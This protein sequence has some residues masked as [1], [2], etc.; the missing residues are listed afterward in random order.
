MTVPY[1]CK[2]CGRR[3]AYELLP[4]GG[5]SLGLPTYWCERCWGRLCGQPLAAWELAREARVLRRMNEG[6]EEHHPAD[7]GGGGGAGPAEETA[8]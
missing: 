4:R 6:A 8:G 2:G 3:A 7:G 1:R 5:D